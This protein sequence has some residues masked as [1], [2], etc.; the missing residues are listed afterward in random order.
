MSSPCP[1]YASGSAAPRKPTSASLPTI[2][3]VDRLGAVPLARVRR[4]L[5]VAELPRGR[6]DQLLLGG[7]RE[8]HRRVSHPTTPPASAASS[9]PSECLAAREHGLEQVA[10]PFDPLERLTHPEAARRQVLGQLVPGS[11]V[12]TGAPGF[13]RTE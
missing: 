9:R 3:A 4:D 7:E 6:A 8:V 12:E 13:G 2:A 10:V 1:P 5:A 11:G